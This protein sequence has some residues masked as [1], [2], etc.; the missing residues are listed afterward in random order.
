MS[1]TNAHLAGVALVDLLQRTPGLAGI[2]V[3]YA[4]DGKRV[5]REYIYLGPVSGPV[6][7]LAFRNSGQ[8]LPRL[9]DIVARLHIEVKM[10]ND[11]PQNAAARAT[12][13][14]A[15][16]EEAIAQDPRLGGVVPGLLFIT[17][18][19]V[20]LTPF[21]LEDGVSAAAMTYQI[22]VQSQLT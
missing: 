15:V 17:V 1:G 18:S 22:S 12:A 10:P 20:E 19:H 21:F 8:R 16:V 11:T 9:E 5:E 6:Q 7:P 14:G 3:D 4:Y 13:L 2:Q